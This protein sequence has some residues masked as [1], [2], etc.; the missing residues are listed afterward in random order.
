ML[1]AA[2]AARSCQT[3]EV[4]AS[5]SLARAHSSSLLQ[6]LLTAARGSARALCAALHKKF[7]VDMVLGL[8]PMA[9]MMS[10]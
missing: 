2:A 9:A 7:L 4:G 3:A 1:A 10:L 6:L 8:G 5:S